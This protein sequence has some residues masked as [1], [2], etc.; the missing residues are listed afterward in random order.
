[1]IIVLYRRVES[2][3]RSFNNS[4]FLLSLIFNS[5]GTKMCPRTSLVIPDEAIYKG[6]DK[7]LI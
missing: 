3:L 4:R 2:W 6:N 1:M 7:V 5:N